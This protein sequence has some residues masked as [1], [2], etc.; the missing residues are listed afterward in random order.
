MM[1]SARSEKD[2]IEKYARRSTNQPGWRNIYQ[3][4]DAVK[5]LIPYSSPPWFILIHSISA[6][7][8]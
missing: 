1:L 5:F 6:H 4:K 8:A 7:P 3:Q 2:L